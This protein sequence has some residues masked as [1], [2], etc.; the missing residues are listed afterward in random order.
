MRKLID[1]Y[2]SWQYGVRHSRGTRQK[3]RATLYWLAEKSLR[4]L[5]PRTYWDM[6]A[7]IDPYQTVGLTSDPAEL[8]QPDNEILRQLQQ[9]ALVGP[10]VVTLHIG[11]GVGRVEFAIAPHVRKCYGIDVSSVLPKV[12]QR[13]L[14]RYDNVEFRTGDGRTLGIFPDAT[15]DV[16]YSTIA[17]QHMPK[18]VFRSYLADTHRALKPGGTLYFMI[19]AAARSESVVADDRDAHTMRRYTLDELRQSVRDVA[20]LQL[21]EIMNEEHVGETPE[22]EVW[23]V[24]RKAE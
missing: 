16:I 24:A 19:P 23:V 11:A 20:R 10:E 12:A 9:R 1:A 15:F 21:V 14:S 8:Y 7:R 2:K 4:Y 17:F 5:P 6:L 22:T 18:D 13:N 3:L